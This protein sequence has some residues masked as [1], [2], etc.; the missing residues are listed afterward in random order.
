MIETLLIILLILA[1]ANIAI[2]L[3]KKPKI[4][5]ESQIKKITTLMLKFDSS[6]ERTEKSIK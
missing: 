5:I 4:E 3:L 6:L 1:I 2:G